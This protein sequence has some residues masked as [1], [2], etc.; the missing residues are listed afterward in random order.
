MKAYREIYERL[1]SKV[2]SNCQ[3]ADLRAA[4]PS[5]LQRWARVAKE[6]QDWQQ[7]LDNCLPGAL[8]QLSKWVI[9]AERR[10][11]LPILPNSQNPNMLQVVQHELNEHQVQ[12]FGFSNL[13]CCYILI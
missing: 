4:W 12:Y 10:L 1:R 7:Y 2:S 13:A 9:E 8:G 3:D 5:L 6:L 11:A